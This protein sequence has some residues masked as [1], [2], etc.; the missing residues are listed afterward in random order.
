MIEIRV[1]AELEYVGQNGNELKKSR[2]HGRGRT[3][4]YNNDRYN[5]ATGLEEG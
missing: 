3:G 2:D 5:I 1:L 4:R